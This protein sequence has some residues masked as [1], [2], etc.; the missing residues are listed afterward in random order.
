M[1]EVLQISRNVAT[2][3]PAE[4]KPAEYTCYDMIPP[5]RRKIN[6]CK[7]SPDGKEALLY[8]DGFTPS[9]G[10][11]N[12]R[13]I[14][15]KDETVTY[16]RMKEDIDQIGTNE[17]TGSDVFIPFEGSPSYPIAGKTFA[18]E[19]DSMDVY[20]RGHNEGLHGIQVEGF[21]GP[22]TKVTIYGIYERQKIN[23]FTIEQ[24]RARFGDKDPKRPY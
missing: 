5:L 4:T 7:V 14:N 1:K 12:N 24:T 3:T 18:P 21:S 13:A 2:S 22:E 20:V 6:D 23:P 8:L 15:G 17:E 16:L 19:T 10:I 9:L 11:A